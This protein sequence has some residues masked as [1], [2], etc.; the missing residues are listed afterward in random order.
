MQPEA[1]LAIRSDIARAVEPEYLAWLTREHT[2]ERVGIEGFISARIFRSQHDGFGRYLILYGLADETVVDSQAYLERLDNPTPWTT[3]MMPH[4]GNFVRGG[5]R[6]VESSGIVCGSA[7]IPVLLQAKSDPVGAQDVARLSDMPGVA[8]IRILRTSRERTLVQSN[9]RSLR[10]GDRSF[11]TLLLIEALDTEAALRAMQALPPGLRE[12]I[13]QE[14]GSH[15]NP[16][17][18]LIFHLNR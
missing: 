6:I 9:E 7:L 18:S 3:R 12:I 8:A 1:L 4:L 13:A 16:V 15:D 2:L 14:A 17:Y 10:S 5:G 11:H